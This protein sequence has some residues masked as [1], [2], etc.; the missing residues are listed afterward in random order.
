MSKTTRNAP[1]SQA[2]ENPLP[3]PMPPLSGAYQDIRVSVDR[4]CLLAGIEAIG[5]MLAADVEAVCGPRHARGS[6]RR[7][8]RWGTT[9]SEL[10][11]ELCQAALEKARRAAP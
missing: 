4:F 2:L 1:S 6:E 8:H 11:A 9:T 3:M 7:G 5:E 10:V